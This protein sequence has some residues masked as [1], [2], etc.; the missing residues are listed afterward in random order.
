MN[1]NKAV[2]GVNIAHLW[3]QIDLQREWMRQLVA[4]YDEA[5]FRP[6]I[7]RSFKFTEAAMAHHYLQDRKNRGKV[8]LIP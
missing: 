5:L 7:D 3:D 4:W 8:L 1:D 2:I 6:T